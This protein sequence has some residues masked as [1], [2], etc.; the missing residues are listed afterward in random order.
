MKGN[1]RLV[2]DAVL[3][4]LRFARAY[5]AMFAIAAAA[6]AATAVL[7]TDYLVS[8]A[9]PSWTGSQVLSW[10]GSLPQI[11]LLAPV[12]TALLRFVILR[13]RRRRYRTWDAR[14]RRV[15][16]VTLILSA[17]TM[18]GGVLFALCL[19][20][21]PRFP[22]R[23]LYAVAAL[24]GTFGGKLAGWWLVMRLAIAPALAAAGTRRYALD[25]AFSFTRR[26]FGTIFAVKFFIYAPLFALIGALM[27]LML[28]LGY[29]PD[30]MAAALA[31]PLPVAVVTLATALVEL[32]DATA[33]ALVAV[34]IVRARKG[35][36]DDGGMS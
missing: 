8:L 28:L 4:S 1:I 21:V 10:A 9:P 13:D 32:V 5:P 30:Q 33:M 35:E 24:V 12:W 16:L 22:I 31:R 36:D 11:V 7:S 17:I 20:L 27:G 15:L 19:D 23:R 26:W 14:V 3:A 2:W 34:R 6:Y 29:R 18:A 25:T